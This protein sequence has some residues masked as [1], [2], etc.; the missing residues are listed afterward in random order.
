MLDLSTA[1]IQL[2]AELSLVLHTL[3]PK[4]S[5]GYFLLISSWA[6]E[7]A[8]PNSSLSPLLLEKNHQPSFLLAHQFYE[9][10]TKMELRFSSFLGSQSSSLHPLFPIGA[11]HPLGELRQPDYCH[12]VLF[13]H[14]GNPAGVSRSG[15]N[16]VPI[17]RFGWGASSWQPI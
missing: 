4:S 14:M 15:R 7:D 1:C 11:A 9:V 8:F 3:T 17:A 12:H 16:W 6:G 13:H 2:Q 10:A 5:V